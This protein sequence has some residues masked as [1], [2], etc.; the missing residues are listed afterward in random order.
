MKANLKYTLILSS[1][2]LLN[3][4]H[5]IDDFIPDIAN[6]LYIFPSGISEKFKELNSADNIFEF[7]PK[8]GM[9]CNLPDGSQVEFFANSFLLNGNPVGCKNVKAV[10][11]LIQRQKGM[12]QN[13]IGTN[14]DSDGSLIS[15]GMVYVQVFCE[16]KEL[17]LAPNR[18][19][20]VRLV[21]ESSQVKDEFEMFYGVEKDNK[22]VWTEADNDPNIQNNVNRAEWSRDSSSKSLIGIICF[23]DRLHWI[24]CDYFT[25]FDS[26]KTTSPCLLAKIPQSGDSIDLVSY[27]VFKNLNAVIFPCCNDQDLGKICFSSLPLGE[28]VE[29]II[30]GKGKSNYYL[31]HIVKLIEK[32]EVNT[33]NLEVKTLE[34]IKKY[35]SSL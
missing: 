35:I 6:S 3:S 12:I 21:L 29:Y 2:I 27:C 18:T 30:I 16:G 17:Q 7:D 19:F 9:I 22:I 11:K 24:N 26:S 33:I 31:G 14:T 5:N 28:K 32:D 34:E 15:G 25:K 8:V 10:I 20:A 1:I 4:C 23:P 13:N